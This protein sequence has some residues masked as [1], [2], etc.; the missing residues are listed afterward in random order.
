[1]GSW[2][3]KLYQE[4]SSTTLDHLSVS[5]EGPYGPHTTQFLRLD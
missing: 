2:S 1:V 4:L 3:N 5:V